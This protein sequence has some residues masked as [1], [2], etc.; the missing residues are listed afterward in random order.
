[1]DPFIAT[2]CAASQLIRGQFGS[3]IEAPRCSVLAR[4]RENGEAATPRFSRL[5]FFFFF[6][7]GTDV[8]F[9]REAGFLPLT[10][11]FKV[12]KIT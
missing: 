9:S 7:F 4:E 5:P 1:M 10:L 12:K 6:F 8:R 11:S 3:R 2:V